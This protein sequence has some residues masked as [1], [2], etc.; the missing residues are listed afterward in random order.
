[1]TNPR[2]VPEIRD[3]AQLLET[4]EQ[5]VGDVDAARGFSEAVQMLDDYLEAEPGTPHRA[6]IQNL[7]LS[8]TRR[9]LQQLAQLERRDFGLW[10]EYAVTALAVVEREAASVLAARPD[11]K[12]DLDAFQERWGDT[13]AQ[14]L[15]R[16][17]A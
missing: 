10:L 6:F 2:S 9:L 17:R 15:R 11:L 16:P 7:K 13:V 12:A 3:A 8:H 5:S 4:W 1:M 14:A